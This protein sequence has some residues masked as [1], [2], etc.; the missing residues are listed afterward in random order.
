MTLRLIKGGQSEVTEVDTREIPRGSSA[1]QRGSGGSRGT[2][3]P[4]K[5][6]KTGKPGK[7]GKTE[8][9]GKTGKAGKAGRR[10]KPG[11]GK[12]RGKQ[13]RHRPVMWA[14]TAG[15]SGAD[16][17]SG[18]SSLGARVLAAGAPESP[19]TLPLEFAVLLRQGEAL[20]WWNE[21][22][23][24]SLWPVVSVLGICAVILALV[25][26]LAPDFWLQPWETLWPPLAALFSPVL[27]IL[28]REVFS[29]RVT[30][31]ADGAVIDVPRFGEPRRIAIG[32]IRKVRRDLWTGGIRLEEANAR[33]RIPPTFAD[34]ARRAIAS[35]GR[36]VLRSR[37]VDDPISWLP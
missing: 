28:I 5:T 17:G 26:A 24:I 32:A 25:T 33:L 36:A 12:K 30:I 9:T 21:K 6:G 7:A 15:D 2:D 8:K 1:S 31:V 22:Q 37:P 11:S 29:M 4:G 13:G 27:A 20:I 3:G 19:G 16:R 14:L 23:M 10:G 35:T 34:D 18:S